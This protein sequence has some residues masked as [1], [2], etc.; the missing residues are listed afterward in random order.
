MNAT[1]EFL[2]RNKVSRRTIDSLA[3]RPSQRSNADLR[4]YRKL[5]RAY[6][7]M[8]MLM[9]TWFSNP[10]FLD[11]SGQ[12]VSLTDAAGPRSVVSLIR[13]SRVQIPKHLALEMMRHSPSIKSDSQGDLVATR[14]VFVLPEFEVPRAAFIVG[15]YLNTLRRNASGRKKNAALLL[16]RSCHV[17]TIDLKKVAPILRDIK[18]R[19]AAFMDSVDGQ[20]E[21]CRVRGA[22][23]RASGELGVLVFAWTKRRNGRQKLSRR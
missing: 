15:N 20:I 14:R 23:P 11:Q 9:A 13:E 19:G 5:M 22:K 4:L 2:R 8:A 10:K 18:E 1:R 17:S 7:D 3:S 16:E 21:A 12:P 6:E